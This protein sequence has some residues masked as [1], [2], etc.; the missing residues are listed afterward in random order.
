MLK[1]FRKFIVMLFM[2]LAISGAVVSGA[3]AAGASISKK[4]ANVTAGSKITLTVRNAGKYKVKWSTSDKNVAAIK[5]NGKKATVTGK[6]AGKA[7]ITAKV[8]GKSYKCKVTVKAAAKTGK[9]SL[10]SSSLTMFV[11][12]SA[13]L[14]V[15]SA[16]NS[17]VSWSTSDKYVAVVQKESEDGKEAKVIAGGIGTCKVTAKV[18]KKSY[19]CKVTVQ[20]KYKYDVTVLNPQYNIYCGEESLQVITQPGLLTGCLIL[21]IKTD[22]PYIDDVSVGKKGSGSS[23]GFWMDGRYDDVTYQTNDYNVGGINNIRIVKG[24]YLASFYPDEAGTYY[25]NIFSGYSSIWLFN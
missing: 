1:G 17:D 16:G 8:D 21:Y 9:S 24:G 22:D 11:R 15:R 3:E 7:V 19:V 12:D 13:M 25:I 2:V 14:T 23:A 20:S 6:K 10:S 4:S 5:T 18:G